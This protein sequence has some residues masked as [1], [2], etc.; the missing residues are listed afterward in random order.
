MPGPSPNRFSASQIKSRLLH[1]AQTSV[2][3]V[4]LTPPPSV[5]GFL[6]SRGFNYLGQGEDVELRCE[7]ASLPGSS[8]ST[9][10][11]ENDYHGVSEKMAYRRLYDSTT[12]FTF[13]VGRDYGVIE[14]FDGWMDYIA[15][16][17][18]LDQFRGEYAHHRM[19]Y[20]LGG[21]GY[22]SNIFISKFEKDLDQ[23]GLNSRR[24]L[25][26]EFVR[27]FPLNMIAT[28]VSYAPS[29]TLRCTVS[30]SYIRYVKQRKGGGFNAL[31]GAQ[32]VGQS[33]IGP[34]QNRTEFLLRNG[35]IAVRETTNG[36]SVTFF[37]D[38]AEPGDLT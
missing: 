37:P 33:Q 13:Y 16:V 21:T 9:H 29:D 26:Y 32:I 22:Q 31:A 6:S 19:N 11:Q 5:I 24:Y 8:F 1:N 23:P 36:S 38:S 10:S 2:Y 12:D 30:M 18:P 34:N 4:R 3:Q 17:D 20:P 15:N 28:P 25:E 14:M 27:A 7:S 35:D